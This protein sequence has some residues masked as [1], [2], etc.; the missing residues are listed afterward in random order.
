MSKRLILTTAALF[1]VAILNP[2]LA[3]DPSSIPGDPGQPGHPP[4]QAVPAPVAI[5]LPSHGP[6]LK[7]NAPTPPPI[8]DLTAGDAQAGSDQQV[9][10]IIG[11]I[12]LP[13]RGFGF[14]AAGDGG[15]N[16][17]VGWCWEDGTGCGNGGV[18]Q[19]IANCNSDGGTL[20]GETDGDTGQEVVKC[21]YPDN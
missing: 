15:Q 13:A 2:S 14:V 21:H 11:V 3:R 8:A 10:A 7:T 4:S 6:M 19:F 12:V 9:D 20:G 1:T 18:D 16:G 5:P 17:S